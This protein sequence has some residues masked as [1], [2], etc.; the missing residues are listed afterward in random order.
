[1]E[2]LVAGVVL[3]AALA[4]L[5]ALLRRSRK[6]ARKGAAGGVM[7]GLGLAFMTIFDP[8]KAESVEEVRQ[9]KE[10]GKAD[11]GESGDRPD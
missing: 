3:C 1:M 6:S 8:L 4:V 11:Q 9:R 7:M 5:P 10:R 2:W